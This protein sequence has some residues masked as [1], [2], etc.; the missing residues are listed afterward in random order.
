M[1]RKFPPYEIKIET[2]NDHHK[3]RFMYSNEA[4][5]ENRPIGAGRVIKNQIR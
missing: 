2:N 1:L 4:V 5:I 3:K